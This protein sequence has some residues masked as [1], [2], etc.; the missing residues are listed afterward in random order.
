MHLL[1]F[2]PVCNIWSC[3]LM[4]MT[5]L[6]FS[7]QYPPGHRLP[8]HTSKK[9]KT[10]PNM[11]PGVRNSKRVR[12]SEGSQLQPQR[13]QSKRLQPSARDGQNVE[14][15]TDAHDEI[16]QWSYTAA[17]EGNGGGGEYSTAAEEGNGGGGEDT[18]AEEDSGAAHDSTGADE[19]NLAGEED[20]EGKL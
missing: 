7:P 14:D 18:T 20:N 3:L 9:R 13:R 15:P 12:A 10:N 11:P 1:S 6:F 8:V 2:I 5:Y 16:P 4:H 17:E 19:D